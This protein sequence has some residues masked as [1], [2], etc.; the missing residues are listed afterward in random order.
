[1]AHHHKVALNIGVTNIGEV[2]FIVKDETFNPKGEGRSRCQ[3]AHLLK[4][5]SYGGAERN[6]EQD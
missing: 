5:E 2:T 4:A 1:M 6:V 3:K